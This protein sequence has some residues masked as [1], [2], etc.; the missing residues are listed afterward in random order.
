M[1]IST[2]VETTVLSKLRLNAKHV[3]GAPD[4]Q[5]PNL[6]AATLPPGTTWL[7]MSPGY[8]HQPGVVVG[9]NVSSSGMIPYAPIP[10]PGMEINRLL[11]MVEFTSDYL[12]EEHYSDAAEATLALLYLSKDD[13]YHERISAPQKAIG[14]RFAFEVPTEH[15]SRDELFS[16]SLTV[17]LLNPTKPVLLRGVWLEV[18]GS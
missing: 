11:V 6:Y 18:E 2:Q 8:D 17:T 13:E 10:V 12:D 16:C 4:Y 1:T 14:D 3:R 9:L 5:T 15:I 7:I